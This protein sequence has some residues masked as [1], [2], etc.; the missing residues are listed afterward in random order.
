[1]SEMITLH[2][3]PSNASFAPHVLLHDAD[4]KLSTS[5]AY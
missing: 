1:M 5:P 4:E 3:H 2:D